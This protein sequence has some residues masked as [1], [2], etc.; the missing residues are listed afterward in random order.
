MTDEQR[1]N[2][3]AMLV[4]AECKL[5]LPTTQQECCAIVARI[6]ITLLG[7]PRS[8]ADLMQLAASMAKGLFGEAFESAD[9]GLRTMWIDMC[10]VALREAIEHFATEENA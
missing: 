9:Y 7:V 3:V 10:E 4:E 6:E 5:R 8:E 2:L 1:Q